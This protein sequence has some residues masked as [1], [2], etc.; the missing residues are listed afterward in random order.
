MN[1]LSGSRNQEKMAMA[2]VVKS[3]SRNKK[4]PFIF[5]LF[6]LLIFVT[7]FLISNSQSQILISS[8]G[9]G[10]PVGDRGS[11]SQS[12]VANSRI[13]SGAAASFDWKLCNASWMVDYIP[14][15]DNWEAI[16]TLKKLER[17]ERHCPNPSS[18]CLVPLPKG[19]KIPVPWPKSRDMVRLILLLWW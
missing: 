5:A 19:Y 11:S 16:K 12:S 7:L 13:S 1:G 17:K 10:Q 15:L 4:C 3:I 18:R 6:L 14:C 9:I 8:T 2:S